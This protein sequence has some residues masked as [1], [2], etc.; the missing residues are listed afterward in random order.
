MWENSSTTPAKSPRSMVGEI[1][2]SIP[3]V[4][5][6]GAGAVGPGVGR[7]CCGLVGDRPRTLGGPAVDPGLDIIFQEDHIRLELEF[8]AGDGPGGRGHTGDGLAA[9]TRGRGG[10]V[11]DTP[12]ER[13]VIAAGCRIGQAGEGAGRDG[14][15]ERCSARSAEVTVPAMWAALAGS[16]T[17]MKT[18]LT[19]PQFSSA[20]RPRR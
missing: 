17:Q 15:G 7:A 11:V 5:V 9:E 10:D 4:A 19:G 8:E 13:E 6:V 18:A 1:S 12:R 14:G 16:R 2:E 20:S 3:V